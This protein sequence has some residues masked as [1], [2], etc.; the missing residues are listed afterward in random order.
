MT[1][2]AVSTCSGGGACFVGVGT[3]RLRPGGA[4]PWRPPGPDV[5]WHSVAARPPPHAPG[6]Q[7]WPTCPARPRVTRP[8]TSSPTHLPAPHRSDGPQPK[9]RNGL[10][11]YF[12]ITARRSTVTRE[13]RGGLTTFFTMA[14]IVVL[15]PIILTTIDTGNG[16]GVDVAGNSLSFASIAAVTALIAGV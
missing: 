14:Y 15:N 16:P 9:P 4:H 13:L 2:R 10:D 1:T 11:R 5:L 3:P 12:E 7:P 8:P 6:V